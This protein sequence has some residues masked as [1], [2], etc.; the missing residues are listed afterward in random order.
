MVKVLTKIATQESNQG[1]HKFSIPSK[2]VLESIAMSSAGDIRGAI[3]ALQFACEKESIAMSSAGDIRGAINALQFACEKGKSQHIIEFPNVFYRDASTFHDIVSFNAVAPTSM[4]KVLTK[5]ATQESNQGCHKFSIPS[6]T[7]L[8]SI[9]MSSAGDIRGAIKKESIAM[10]SAGDIRGAINALQ[11]AC[12]KESIAMSSAGDIRGAINALQ[13]ACEKDTGDLMSGGRLKGNASLKKQSSS[14]SN[15]MKSK[16]KSES[17]ANPD[18]E[19]AS[20]GGRDT[21]LFL[22]RALGKILYCKRDDPSNYSDLPGLPS[23]LSEHE[24]DPL[25]INPEYTIQIYQD[26]RPIYQ[27][28]KAIDYRP[29][30]Q[31]MKEIDYRPIYQNM[32]EI[33]YRPILHYSDLPGLPSHLSEHERDPLIINPED[34]VE[35]SHLSGEYFTAY[36]HQNYL[37]FYSNID[38]LVRSTEYLSDADYLTIDWA[39]RS[40]LQE[41]AASVATRGIIHCNSS[42]SKHDA[43]SSGLGWRP[44]NKP[45]WYTANKTARQNAESCRSLFKTTCHGCPP[46]V[47]QTEILPFLAQINIPLHNPGQFSCLQEI[48]RFSKVRLSLRSEK[49]DEKDVELDTDDED[50]S[51]VVPFS[52]NMTT[53]N[54]D[55]ITNSQSKINTSQEEEEEYDIEEFDDF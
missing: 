22:F 33:D 10:S 41:Y 45:Q 11:F 30:C 5:I 54:D 42:R 52:A 21:S 17:P 23:H 43:V 13:F 14:R 29:I 35:K 37:E 26:Y 19:L 1:C 38:D 53:D 31:N 8:E 48:C 12:E 44:L 24:R 32:K 18:C 7:V 28:M 16:T 47:L 20:I 46:V 27:N 34:V 39:S 55:V 2:T 6:K 9:A 51:S 15:K 50:A 40:V 25:I 49:L 4:V 36:L 3:N